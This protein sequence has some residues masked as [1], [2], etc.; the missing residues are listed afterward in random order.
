LASI[1]LQLLADSEERNGLGRRAAE[2][3]RSQAGATIRTADALEE[4]LATR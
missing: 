4:L 3:V 1:F 2:T